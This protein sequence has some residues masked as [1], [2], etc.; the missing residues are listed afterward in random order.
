M[1]KLICIM[2]VICFIFSI[3]L[4]S[5]KNGG[6]TEDRVNSKSGTG[7]GLY[8]PEN[9][10]KKTDIKLPDG[11]FLSGSDNFFYY[12]N[13]YYFSCVEYSAEGNII[14]NYLYSADTTGGNLEFFPIVT[15][16]P[17]T[18]PGL[19]KPAG[20]GK[21]AVLEYTDTPAD[22]RKYYLSYIDKN[23]SL[24][25][26]V[27]LNEI[28]PLSVSA[29]SLTAADNNAVCFFSDKHIVKISE[30]GD[31]LSSIA[32]D[33]ENEKIDRLYF[34][35]GVMYAGAVNENL[36]GQYFFYKENENGSLSSEAVFITD[37]NENFYIGA[38][39]DIFYYKDRVFYGLDFGGG[40]TALCNYDFSAIEA[41]PKNAAVCDSDR[42][43]C[44]YSDI[45]TLRPYAAILTRIPQEELKPRT[46]I[47]LAAT[48]SGMFTNSVVSFNRESDKYYVEVI[49]YSGT[50]TMT[51]GEELS[52]DMLAG[53]T[54]DLIVACGDGML[55]GFAEK[56]ILCD[57]YSFMDKNNSANTLARDDLLQCVKTPFETNGKLCRLVTNFSIDTLIAKEKNVGGGD[58]WTL[59]EILN[60]EKSLPE[61]TTLFG[62]LYDGL[63][64][65]IML[66]LGVNGFV[67]Y[68][69]ASCSFETDEFIELLEYLKA[70]PKPASVVS[71]TAIGDLMN[72]KAIIYTN[73]PF[74]TP[75]ISSFDDYTT[76][77]NYFNFEKINII[78]YPTSFGS[79]SI[80]VP[81]YE[82]GITEASS[83]K[84][85][86]WEFLSHAM[87]DELLFYETY[88]HLKFPSTVS[89]MEKYANL[90]CSFG[91]VYDIN[92]RYGY[93]KGPAEYCIENK[94]DNEE[95]YVLTKKDLEPF[96]KMLDNITFVS[97]D[98]KSSNIDNFIGEEIRIFLDSGKSAAETAKILQSRTSIY[99]NETK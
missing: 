10:F 99:L 52:Y 57:L 14:G 55:E 89:A 86:A 92:S 34:I 5:C 87:R 74:L 3:A 97:T 76:I 8:Y 23:G 7:D 37:Y 68:E 77:M 79:G 73:A 85:G 9:V 21:F 38:D 91:Y 94:Y 88:Y 32:F 35:G 95:V 2:L 31:I 56:N 59:R 24:L 71:T 96:Y 60:F 28:L 64:L 98:I 45:N 58:G 15:A 19:I 26:S 72:D 11:V 47:K 18:S 82:Y 61:G 12:D 81:Q 49:Y 54:P 40:E 4:S 1:K 93:A 62:G 13:R 50:D 66:K 39:Y 48:R 6:D 17:D 16:E 25:S 41:S 63:V 42:M 90:Y 67:N 36:P 70:Q 84:D 78:G 27:Y 69:N 51:P 29:L 22:E 30:N 80:I 46:L 20:N 75:A 44:I 83:Q 65:N 43:A 33:R 53:N